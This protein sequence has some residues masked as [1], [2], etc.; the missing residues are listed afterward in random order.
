MVATKASAQELYLAALA[1]G[2][3]PSTAQVMAEIELAESGGNPTALGDVSLEDST[4]GPSYG[5]AQIRTLK[6]DTG[7]GSNR[8]I[9]HLSTGLAA[10]SAAAYDISGHG[11]NFSPWTTFRTGAYRQF[12]GTVGT[13]AGAPVSAGG[14]GATPAG[15]V[16][17]VAASG[18]IIG[19]AIAGAR[20]L[21]LEA[22]LVA[23]GLGLIGL[24]LS[25]LASP[26]IKAKKAEGEQLVGKLL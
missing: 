16:L 18:G 8:D 15:A 13:A 4:W 3:T 14:A 19:Q 2:F 21:A 10:Q 1:A 22:V 23:A 17:P 20:E 11:A 24:G 6:H 9:S 12:A 5:V 7:S 25:R 26:R